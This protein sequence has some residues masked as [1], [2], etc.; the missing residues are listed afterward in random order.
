MVLRHLK[1][2]IHTFPD[3]NRG[4]HHD[5]FAPSV[6]LVQLEH[7]LDI[8]ICFTH[9]GFHFDRQIIPTFQFGRR[10]DLIGSLYFVQMFQDQCIRQF[11]HNTLITPAGKVVFLFHANLVCTGTSVHHIGWR[12][13]WLTGKDIHNCFCCICLELLVFKLKFHDRDPFS[14]FAI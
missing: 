8:G 10:R 13:V 9:T 11:R 14:F 2:L 12:E 5:E 4:N 3:R 6:V 7:G 1:R